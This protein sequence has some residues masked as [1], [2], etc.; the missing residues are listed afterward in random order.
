MIAQLQ[1]D[2][3][4]GPLDN[5]RLGRILIVRPTVETTRIHRF[6]SQAVIVTAAARKLIELARNGDKIQ[7][8]V[9]EGVLQDP[10][11]HPEFHEISENL[12]ELLDKHFPKALMCLWAEATLLESS[13]ARHALS[14]YDQPI[15]RLDAGTQKTYAALT[16]ANPKIFRDVVECLGRL[17]NGRLIVQTRFIRGEVDN[18]SENEV[19]A[20]LRHISDIKPAVVH[21][22]TPA[23][24]K[25]KKEIPVTKTRM[26][27]IAEL[28]T[29]KTGIPV[30]VLTS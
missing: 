16:G 6:P 23:K 5:P 22:T 17:G 18:S 28:V 26:T 7:A 2:I 15:L 20:W 11:K 14:F 3:V 1:E 12:R 27:Q 4:Q 21:I 10:T 8:L 13:Q 29:S 9:V 19:K 24:A 30:E 25:G